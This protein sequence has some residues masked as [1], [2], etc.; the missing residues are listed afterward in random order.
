MICFTV[1]SLYLV[2]HSSR[3]INKVSSY[4][5]PEPTWDA[6]WVVLYLR[7]KALDVIPPHSFNTSLGHLLKTSH[8]KHLGQ[9]K[10]LIISRL[11]GEHVRAC[12]R[13]QCLCRGS[14]KIMFKELSAQTRFQMVTAPLSPNSDQVGN[15]G[16]VLH[17]SVLIKHSVSVYLDDFHVFTIS[18]Y[19]F[20][21][22]CLIS[23]AAA[24][25]KTRLSS[26]RFWRAETVNESG[27]S[28]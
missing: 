26:N 14:Q 17:L 16:H 5:T 3:G 25:L 24:Q 6:W 8:R 4:L 13:E 15:A 28:W 1:G 20:R 22:T 7:K 10:H 19:Y 11:I 27:C 12:P 2:S 23:K 18:L 9:K 21:T